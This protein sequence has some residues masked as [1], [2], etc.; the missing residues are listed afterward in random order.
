VICTCCGR[1]V[2]GVVL[3]GSNLSGGACPECVGLA[4]AMQELWRTLADFH[5]PPATAFASA[6]GHVMRV[7]IERNVAP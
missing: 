3:G 7:T 2:V 4:D 5:E 1:Q 6:I